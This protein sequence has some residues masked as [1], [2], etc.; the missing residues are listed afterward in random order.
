[1][2]STRRWLWSSA[3]S[4]F[5]VPPPPPPRGTGF[6]CVVPAVLEDQAGLELTERSSCLCLPGAACHPCLSYLSSMFLSPIIYHL[7]LLY[8]SAIF[9]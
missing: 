9:L 6:L 5:F 3:V 8:I 2:R 4:F 1:L 7:Y